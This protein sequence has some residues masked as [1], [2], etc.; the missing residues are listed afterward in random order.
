MK[1][2]V[3]IRGQT[4]I[5]IEIRR[6]YNIKPNTRLEW[7]DDGQTITVL[8]VPQ[9]PIKSLRGKFK[10]VNLREALLKSRKEERSRV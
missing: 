8:P 2:T 3:T 1:S 6:R 5:P 10:D 9:N 4:V 7:I